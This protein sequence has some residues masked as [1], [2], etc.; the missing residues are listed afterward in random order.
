MDAAGIATLVGSAV[1]ALGSA[2]AV[3][4]FIWNKVERRFTKIEAE[5]EKC[6]LREKRALHFSSGQT[7]VIELLWR[8]VASSNP[9]RAVLDRA[10]KL[11][12][13]LKHG[14]GCPLEPISDEF[15]E[16]AKRLD[17]EDEG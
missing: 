3:G 9:G 16:L 14:R 13:D 12:E 7:T 10:K 8:E 11:L 15:R 6:R 17:Q 5:L 2:G 4:R 1:T